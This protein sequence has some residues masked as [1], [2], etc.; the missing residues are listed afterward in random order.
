M[1]RDETDSTYHKA[2]D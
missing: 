1:L 2:S